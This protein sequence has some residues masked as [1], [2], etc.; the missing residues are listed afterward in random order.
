M[1]TVTDEPHLIQLLAKI[2][3]THDI[4]LDLNKVAAV[5]PGDDGPTPRA[6]KE[7]LNKISHIVRA[8]IAPI[9]GPSSPVTPKKR[10]PRKKANETPT[11]AGPS[12]KRKRVAGDASANEDEVHVKEEEDLP[13]EDNKLLAEAA[14]KSEPGDEAIDT[15]LHEPLEEEPANAENGKTD[16]E[17]TEYNDEDTESDPDMLTQ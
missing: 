13:E 9:S 1:T 3:E 7:R 8:G 11:S 12:R 5:W 6:L 16:P 4:S 17:W 10:G 2:L 15:V 14:I